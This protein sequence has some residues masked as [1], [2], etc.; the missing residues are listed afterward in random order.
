MWVSVC[1]HISSTLLQNRTV[2]WRQFCKIYKLSCTYYSVLNQMTKTKTE[3][4]FLEQYDPF[5][6]KS[7]FPYSYLFREGTETKILFAYKIY[8]WSLKII[9]WRKSDQIAPL[10]W[11]YI[12]SPDLMLLAK[13]NGSLSQPLYLVCFLCIALTPFKRIKTILYNC[14]LQLWDLRL[15]WVSGLLGIWPHSRK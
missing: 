1:S 9:K 5:Q 6:K 7:I 2:K 13:V 12:C 15:V 4:S 14:G 11:N 10:L 3:K 8:L